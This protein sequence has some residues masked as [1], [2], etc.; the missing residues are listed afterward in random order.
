MKRP[1]VPPE[2]IAMLK[3][4]YEEILFRAMQ[5]DRER[6]SMHVVPRLGYI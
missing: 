4:N 2:R 3:T 6:A 1:G 5:E